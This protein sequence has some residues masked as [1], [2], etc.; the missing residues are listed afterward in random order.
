M[1][2]S[3]IIAVLLFLSVLL[4]AQYEPW[5][6]ARQAGEETSDYG[7]SV[8]VDSNGN[9]YVFGYFKGIINYGNITIISRGYTDIFVAKIDSNGSLQ[10]IKQAGGGG[11]SSCAFS[12]CIVVT[13]SGIYIT[14][15]FLGTATFGSTTLNNNGYYDIFVAK[16]DSNGNWL[17]AKQAGGTDIDISY[18]IAVDSNG[19]SYITGNF[20]SSSIT[21]GS[22]QITNCHL[23]TNDIFVAK[24]NSY[25]NWLWAKQIGG[26]DFDSGN[27]IAVDSSNNIYITGG[28][29]SAS[30][31]FGNITITNTNSGET[32]IFVA[33][34]DSYGNWVAATQ[35]GGTDIDS[36]ESIAVDSS[37]NSYITGSFFSN[38]ITFG[39]ITLTNS[40]RDDIF[41]AK[42]DS[43]VTWSWA[44]KAGGNGYDDATGIAIDTNGNGYVTGH[45]ENSISFGSS[46]LT[47]QGA[48][49]IFIAKMNSSGVWLWQKTAGGQNSD[50]SMG[51]CV[52]SDGNSYIT[53]YFF[54]SNIS[55][56]NTTLGN[57]NNENPDLF[58]SKLDSSGNWQWA[59][60]A[61]G[62]STIDVVDIV[63]DNN[64]NSYISGNFQ[65]S[66]LTWGNSTLYN[67]GQSDI[68]VA[69]MSNNGV[70]LWAKQA[71]GQYGDTCFNMTIDGS[72]DI[73]LTG[74]FFGNITFGTTPSTTLT[75]N[76]YSDI[77]IAKIDSDGNWLWAKQAGG[78]S[79][80]FCYGIAVDANENIYVTG[81][82]V[83]N[84]TFG[85]IT[86]SGYA[87]EDIFIAKTDSNGNWLWAKKAGGLI[88]N[89]GNSI[90]V[91]NA[92][93]CY[94]YGYF[95]ESATFGDATVTSN[96]GDGIYV[97]KL[98]SDGN[99][100]W[101]TSANAISPKSI[102]VDKNGNSYI[103]GDFYSSVTFGNTTLTSSNNFHLF[104]AKLDSNGNWLW[105]KQNEGT[106]KSGSDDVNIDDSGNCFITGNFAGSA[107]FGN[108]TLISRGKNDIFV[109]RLDSNG[110]WIWVNQVGGTNN[111]YGRGIAVDAN[112][113]NYV[114]GN[115]FGNATIGNT[116]FTCRGYNNIFVAKLRMPYYL[117]N[118]PVVEQGITITVSGGDADKG[119]IN[120][121]FPAI[122][123]PNITYIK[124]NFILDS[125]ITNWTITLQT[126]AAYGAYYQ[127]NTWQIV[128]GDG[129]KIILAIALGKTK[130]T[131]EIPVIIAQQDNT[132]PVV[133][134]AFCASVNSQ[135][136]INLMWSTQSET[137][138]NGYYLLRATIADISQAIVISPLIQATNTSQQQVYLFTDQDVYETAIYYY[139]LE[140]QDY[141][142][143][144]TCFGPRS[145][146]FY[147]AHNNTPEY[148]LITGI[149]SIYPNP[150]NPSTTIN[151]ELSKAAE[152]KIEIYNNRGQLVRT[153][154]LGPKDKG[155]YKL[156]WEGKDNN[157]CDCGCG[158][159][160]IRMQADKEN[161][162]QKVILLK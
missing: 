101:V 115:L 112:G 63:V 60:Q 2:K 111:D 50:K 74:Y 85:G 142:G 9:S 126:T 86:L 113:Y 52:N 106:D 123:N 138:L 70:F 107:I 42:L 114:T 87:D 109:A 93:N 6:W 7:Y 1:K 41:V 22:T 18:G 25:G 76:G 102:A 58:I 95:M 130:G 137:G 100:L 124:L 150:F 24:L 35:A 27:G 62:R 54:S 10:W 136:G 34:L 66:K 156:Y 132:L 153:F 73:Y 49:D 96:T 78:P 148:Q 80:D 134:S 147:G 67:S 158:I 160:F 104:V 143:N 129:Q 89:F 69:K 51:I 77:F 56:G 116:T 94:A 79:S 53:G 145:I 128:Y 146:Y 81:C 36:S 48:E 159:Y 43:N 39:S 64:G 30:I 8:S 38:S 135:K 28:F 127:N 5:L 110:N 13:S 61:E 162:I 12:Q 133:L 46:I 140:A 16:L 92:G 23:G 120:E 37:G 99:W 33:K 154:T 57:S 44:N 59:K 29:S 26:I 131:I 17:W 47:S 72:G 118:I 161:Y 121:T 31:S 20:F 75:S 68:F 155:R 122:P 88:D 144:I 151:Y 119:K 71:G 65:S 103:T 149:R 4:F 98:D 19:N 32:D 91:D 82:F 139:W 21:F 45:F 11:E 152:V 141:N 83:Y 157:Y 117:N 105:A 90:S 125:S 84:I 108:T 14:G 40:G 3:I 55:F 15:V 97:A